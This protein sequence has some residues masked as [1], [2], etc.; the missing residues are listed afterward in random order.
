MLREIPN[1]Q[2]CLLVGNPRGKFRKTG[3]PFTSSEFRGVCK[4]GTRYQVGRLA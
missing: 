2:H 1:P 4:N 3:E